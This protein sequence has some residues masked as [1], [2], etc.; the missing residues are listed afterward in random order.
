ML[1]KDEWRCFS[2]EL[3]YFQ[4]VLISFKTHCTTVEV[5][6]FFCNQMKDVTKHVMIWSCDGDWMFAAQLSEQPC[7]HQANLFAWSFKTIYHNFDN[8]GMTVHDYA[9]IFL[10]VQWTCSVVSFQTILLCHCVNVL[11]AQSHT[12]ALR[13]GGDSCVLLVLSSGPHPQS[14]PTSPLFPKLDFIDS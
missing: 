9:Y 6:F 13:V 2:A 11:T 14:L 1:W 3:S 10:F 4:F 7:I 5:L 12:P 8:E